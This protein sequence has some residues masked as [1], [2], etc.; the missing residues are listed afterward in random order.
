MSIVNIT[1]TTITVSWNVPEEKNGVITKY[2]VHYDGK[3]LTK[4]N[5]NQ[6]KQE[7]SGCLQLLISIGDF[8]S[9]LCGI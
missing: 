1:N 9:C 2:E 3:V 7:V 5:D 6:K 4:N 8:Y